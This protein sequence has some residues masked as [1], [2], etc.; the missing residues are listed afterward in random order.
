MMALRTVALPSPA[1]KLR[2]LFVPYCTVRN[3]R[4]HRTADAPQMLK[5][6]WRTSRSFY[7]VSHSKLCTILQRQERGSKNN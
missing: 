4:L 2:E 1:R 5:D 7:N 6:G 3:T